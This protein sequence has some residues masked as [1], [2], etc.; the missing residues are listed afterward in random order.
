MAAA[1]AAG[2]AR[3]A[4]EGALGLIRQGSVGRARAILMEGLASVRAHA[5]GD[6][7]ET[8][9]LAALVQLAAVELTER[10]LELA[11]YEI[12]RA[13]TRSPAVARLESLARVALL[14]LRGDSDRALAMA[15]V[16]GRVEDPELEALRQGARAMAARTGRLERE[17]Q[18]LRD[19]EVWARDND[20]PLVRCKLR[21]WQGWAAYTRGE[22]DEAVALLEDALELAIDPRTRMAA[23]NSLAEAC[24]EAGHYDRAFAA[25]AEARA[26]AAQYRHPFHEA[27]AEAVLRFAAYRT[28]RADGVDEELVKAAA[29]LGHTSLEAQVNL[30]EGAVAWRRGDI[31]TAQRLIRNAHRLWRDVG[32]LPGALLTRAFLLALGEETDA[33]TVA[34][35][36][37]HARESDKPGVALQTLGLLVLGAPP[38]AAAVADAARRLAARIPPRYRNIRREV[39]SVAECL[40]WIDEAMS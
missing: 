4:R 18:V 5:T 29:E 21:Q 17:E 2:I 35:L 40:R 9:L 28:D 3:E 8:L 33:A 27:W 24:V 19:V 23:L 20:A 1:D 11:L 39:A 15:D 13:T 32:N 25:A 10:S 6:A 16:L 31:A 30:N 26:L 36:H 12:G 34:R 37:E 7:D 14:A 22:Y 38:H